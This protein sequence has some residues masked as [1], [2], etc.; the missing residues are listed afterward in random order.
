MFPLRIIEEFA[1]T[2]TLVFVF[3]VIFMQV[4]FY[5]RLLAGGLSYRFGWHCSCQQS[6]HIAWQGF[7]YLLVASKHLFSHMLTMVYLSHKVSHDH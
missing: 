5:L 2:L 3:T 7:S 1:N 4:K 6:Q